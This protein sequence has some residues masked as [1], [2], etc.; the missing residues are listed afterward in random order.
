VNRHA[1]RAIVFGAAALGA[2]CAL[3][4]HPA[5]RDKSKL[6][7]GAERTALIQR[8]QLWKPTRVSAM[9]MRSGPRRDGAFKPGATIRCE[10]A[11]VQYNG[12]SP[13]FGC[14]VSPD[15]IV[16]VKYG[17]DN[18]EVYAGVATSRLLWAL[19]FGADAMYPVHVWCHGCPPQLVGD[20]T[21]PGWTYFDFAAIERKMPGHDI[22]TSDGPGWTWP[23][24]NLVDERVGGAPRPERD[25]LKLLAVLV[26]HS[27]NKREQ[28][29]LV[30]VSDTPKS[31]LAECS[32][33][34]MM[35]HDVGLTFGEAN[36]LDRASIG[37]VNYDGWS[38]MSIW[39]DEQHCVGNLAPSEIG[40]LRDPFISEGGRRF[41]S[42][43]LGQLT[44]RQ[45][46]DLF[47]VAR[48]AEKPA[49]GQPATVGEWV[50]AFKQKRA[51]IASASCPS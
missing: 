41:L 18:G 11:D 29:R 24:L 50:E 32:Q 20:S 26:Q 35:I 19:G 4:T 42:N 23:E 17:R 39:R 30:C 2:S 31:Q 51:E 46:I 5:P 21:K 44:N 37:S 15:D 22:E 12:T 36:L 6:I 1:L 49:K 14:A 9:D 47:T 45:L 34:F 13:K 40:T 7:S 38:R 28:Q 33:P 16:K 25:A 48:F 10:Y 3:L 43:L 8:A 27:D